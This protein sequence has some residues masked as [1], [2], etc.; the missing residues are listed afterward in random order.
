LKAQSQLYNETDSSDVYNINF[1]RYGL[2]KIVNTYQF[3]GNANLN[4]PV[5]FG[6]VE[7]NQSYLGTGLRSSSM[8]FRDDE[9]LD[10]KYLYEFYKDIFL[11]ANQKWIYSSDSR[12]IGFNKSEK[13]RSSGGLKYEFLQNSFLDASVGYED[14]KQMGISS[15]GSV[16]NFNG[17]LN[18]YNLEDYYLSSKLLGEYVSLKDSRKYNVFDWKALLEREFDTINNLRIDL[19]FKNLNQ[20]FLYPNLKNENSDYSIEKR[21]ETKLSGNLNANFSLSDLF[22]GGLNLVLDNTSVERYYNQFISNSQLTGVRRSLNELLINISGD[23][24]YHNDFMEQS[25]ELSYYTRNEENQLLNEYNL[26]KID[27]NAMSKQEI[28]KDNISSRTQLRL[29]TNLEAGKKDSITFNFLSS[30]FRYDTPSNDNNDERDELSLISNLR[31]S[32]KFSEIL[33]ASLTGEVQLIHLVFLKS[34]RSA[35][36]NWNRIIR[37]NQDIAINTK[38]FSMNPSFEILANYTTYDFEDISPGVQS[39]SFRQI[40]YRDSLNYSFSKRFYVK[41]RLSIRYFERGILF[42][43]S[44]SESPQN[45]NFEHFTKLMLYYNSSENLSFGSGARYYGLNQKNIGTYALYLNDIYQISFGPEIEVIY[46]SG[47]GLGLILHGWYEF[48][49]TNNEV[50]YKG[51]PNIFLE[52]RI[53][54]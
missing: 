12:S 13:L 26:D 42:W 9:F 34:S 33:T 18:R 25:L 28:I 36:N 23:I 4:F 6:K 5:L 20:D 47:L 53:A 35:L 22:S 24:S 40:A 8:S 17:F 43:D 48:Q 50:D 21:H 27:F 11:T 41:S 37:L 54:L 45:S 49:K 10:F 39:F 46:N 32:H 7:L 2:D 19:R 3:R 44:F 51:I 1:I 38:R 29:R 30:I 16:M 52:T 31:Y 14:N 15:V